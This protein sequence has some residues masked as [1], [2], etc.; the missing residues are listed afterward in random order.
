MSTVSNQPPAAEPAEPVKSTEPTVPAGSTPPMAQRTAGPSPVAA[1][2]LWQDVLLLLL[3]A[4]AGGTATWY[5]H[6]TA[7]GITAL[8]EQELLQAT[9]KSV[10]DSFDLDLV[11]ASEAVRATAFMVE[12]QQGL[13][14]TEFVNFARF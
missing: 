11:R 6:H 1:R 5:V 7:T 13:Q 3:V 10:L 4:L 8:R 14:R 2:R 9:S 12:T